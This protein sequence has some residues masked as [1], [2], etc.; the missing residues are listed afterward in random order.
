VAGLDFYQN[1]II[2]NDQNM[3]HEVKYPVRLAK[4]NK[5]L[6]YIWWTETHKL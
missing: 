6:Q 4:E 1:Q 2:L 3:D 5:N